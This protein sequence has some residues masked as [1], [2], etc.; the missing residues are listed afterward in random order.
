MT[1]KEKI[2][3]QLKNE[4]CATCRYRYVGIWYTKINCTHRVKEPKSHTCS[5]WKEDNR[6][7]A[8]TS[9][10]KSKVYTPN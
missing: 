1:D 5:H 2:M 10:A 7:P 4:T 9:K 3:K 6:D 8:W